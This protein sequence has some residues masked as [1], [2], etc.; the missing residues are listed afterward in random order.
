MRDLV[1][2]S[3]LEPVVDRPFPLDEAVKAFQRMEEAQQFGKIVLP[4][5]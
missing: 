4:I 3:K 2:A 5:A 1:T